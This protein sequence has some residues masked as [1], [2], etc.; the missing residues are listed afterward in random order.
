MLLDLC[1]QSLRSAM[2]GAT[3][4]PLV[5]PTIETQSPEKTRFLV[6]L[7]FIQCL[8]NPKYLHCAPSVHLR[9]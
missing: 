8:S 2:N 9:P 6:E 5:P 3:S 4:P 7:E 1:A